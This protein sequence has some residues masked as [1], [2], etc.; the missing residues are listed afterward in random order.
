M[1]KT[2]SG[3]WQSGQ[4]RL[5]DLPLPCPK[6]LS[7]SKSVEVSK[8]SLEDWK[9]FRT[10]L[11]SGLMILAM[12][13]DSLNF[14]FVLLFIYIYVTTCNLRINYFSIKFIKSKIKGEFQK[15]HFHF[16]LFFFFF[17]F[18]ENHYIFSIR[19]NFLFGERRTGRNFN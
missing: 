7:R 11:T 3:F 19:R 12:D 1:N 9:R 10:V 14:A 5:K 4:Q 17:F 15:F 8:R 2:K 18:F 6:N 13:F 16:F